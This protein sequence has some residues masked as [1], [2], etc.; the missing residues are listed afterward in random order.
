MSSPTAVNQQKIVPHLWFT[1]D[2]RAAAEFYTSVFPGG[3]ITGVS[4]YPGAG[5]P[6]FLQGLAGQELAFDFEVLGCRFAAINGGEAPFKPNPSVSFAITCGSA[7]EVDALWDRLSEGGAELMP[8]GSYPFSERYGWVQDRFGISWQLLFSSDA[9]QHQ[10]RVAPALMFTGEN[11]GQAEQAMRFYMGIF[12]ES[13]FDGDIGRYQPDAVPEAG[14]AG[15]VSSA[16]FRLAG[17]RFLAM[18]SG[19]QH[20]FTF[21]EAVSFLIRCADQNE[22]D[23]YWEALSAD[24]A[25]ERCGWLKDRYGLSWQVVPRNLS[26]LLQNPD[27][28]TNAEAFAAFL[29]MSKIDLAAF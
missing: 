16:A 27:G 5:L 12:P 10:Q 1:H 22:I 29:R 15:M 13:R 21:N 19:W 9:E 6:D 18:D 8:L 3:K 7:G 11:T 14:M 23:T 20:D 24:P 17:Q 28:S 26:E 2:A 25:A 4:R